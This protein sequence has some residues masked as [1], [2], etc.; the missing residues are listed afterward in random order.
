MW[1]NSSDVGFIRFW[2]R[3]S[4]MTINDREW[5]RLS[6]QTFVKT[7]ALFF[8]LSVV[9]AAQMKTGSDM[10]GFA[11]VFGLGAGKTATDFTVQ[12]IAVRTGTSTMANV[13]WPGES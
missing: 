8:V 1:I 10:P 6:Y 11:E 7:L 5:D 4:E 2:R 13:L 9:C 3:G 12:E